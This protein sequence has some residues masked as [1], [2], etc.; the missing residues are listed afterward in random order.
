[1]CICPV[2]FL[3]LHFF[4]TL[5]NIQVYLETELNIPPYGVF[6]AIAAFTIIVGLLLGGVRFALCVVMV[7]ILHIWGFFFISFCFIFLHFLLEVAYCGVFCL[8]SMS[9]R[10]CVW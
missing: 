9:I 8:N 1:M 3:I 6:I 5:Q 4:P 2:S 10:E 7:H